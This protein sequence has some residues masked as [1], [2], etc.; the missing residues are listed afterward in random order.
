MSRAEILV[1][2]TNSPAG[3]NALRWATDE[4]RRTHLRLR[5][6]HVLGWPYGTHS[7]G[8]EGRLTHDELDELY[9][10]AVAQAFHATAPRPDEILEFAHGDAGPVLVRESRNAAA[11][12]I[13]MPEHVG[14]GRV[15]A[16]SVAHYCL[17]H[18]VC[19]VV[20]VPR[21][22]PVAHASAA[23]EVHRSEVIG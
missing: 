23:A 6:V 15:L 14:L 2:F 21:E 22:M 19:P 11:L 7:A 17:G 1:G 13:G 12:V 8:Q 3:E 10:S 4:A 18:A 9:R 16:G 5:A 20:A